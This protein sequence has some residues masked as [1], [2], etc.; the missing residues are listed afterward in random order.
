MSFI[1]ERGQCDSKIEGTL[2]RKQGADDTRKLVEEERAMV[3]EIRSSGSHEE[4][5]EGEPQTSQ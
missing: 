1:V 5:F 4:K 3:R 2:G